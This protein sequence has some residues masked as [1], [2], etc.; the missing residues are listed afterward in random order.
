LADRSDSAVR[1]PGLVHSKKDSSDTNLHLRG[2]PLPADSLGSKRVNLHSLKSGR[3]SRPMR[4]SRAGCP[5]KSNRIKASH[6]SGTLGSELA[7]RKRPFVQTLSFRRSKPS[8]P[9]SPNPSKL[10]LDGSGAVT[11]APS[12]AKPVTKA[13]LEASAGELVT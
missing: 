7:G 13:P 8:A 6:R 4:P 3:T 9:K 12:A 2:D 11:A 10:M 5:A 1:R